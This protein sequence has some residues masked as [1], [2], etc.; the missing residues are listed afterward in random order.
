MYLEIRGNRNETQRIKEKCN[1]NTKYLSVFL[2]TF[3]S[4]LCEYREDILPT[5]TI[6]SMHVA[7]VAYA[8]CIVKLRC[9]FRVH[10]SHAAYTVY[11]LRFSHC[12]FKLNSSQLSMKYRALSLTIIVDANPKCVYIHHLIFGI[13]K[14]NE[15]EKQKTENEMKNGTSTQ[16]SIVGCLRKC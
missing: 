2:S 14:V 9:L 8:I 3:D 12:T 6:Q 15:R 5:K 10:I 4:W 16:T 11:D 13:N 1:P 7:L